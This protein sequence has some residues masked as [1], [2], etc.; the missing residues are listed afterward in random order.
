MPAHPANNNH[1]PYRNSG[2][3]GILS[4][5]SDSQWP[6]ESTPY[7]EPSQAVTALVLSLLG[8]VFF[9]PLA[10]FAW[11]MANREIQAI[12]EGRRSP[13]GESMANVARILG[14][15]AT[16]L[17]GL[18]LIVAIILISGWRTL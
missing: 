16:V 8:L 2:P 7:G 17:M 6:T 4:V 3:T 14:A 13:E 10:P 5:M 1:D 15:I 11:V 18:G 9:P 12:R